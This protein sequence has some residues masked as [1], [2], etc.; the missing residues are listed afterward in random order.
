[1]YVRNQEK[2]RPGHS[3]DSSRIEFPV[4]VT[5]YI[6][7]LWLPVA[8]VFFAALWYDRREITAQLSMCELWSDPWLGIA[9]KKPVRKQISPKIRFKSEQEPVVRAVCSISGRLKLPS[10]QEEQPHLPPPHRTKRLYWCA[11][12][13]R[14][15]TTRIHD[16]GV[17]DTRAVHSHQRRFED[18]CGCTSSI[19]FHDPSQLRAGVGQREAHLIR[20]LLSCSIL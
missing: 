6:V 2:R 16:Y 5:R 9:L 12:S 10:L 7:C 4:T 17:V 14:D 19:C 3:Y 18:N 13:H 1:M 20:S 15:L 11:L 8:S